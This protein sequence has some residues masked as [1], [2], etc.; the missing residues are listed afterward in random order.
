VLLDRANTPP[1]S[2]H[3]SMVC[4]F[5]RSSMIKPE[6]VNIP[7]PTML[8]ITRIVAEK[9]PISLFNSWLFNRKADF[10]FQFMVI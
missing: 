10:S 4:G 2:Q 1:T 6:V 3:N 8:A 7:V 9:K 5:P